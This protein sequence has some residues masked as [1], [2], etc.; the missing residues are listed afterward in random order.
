MAG[1]D[2]DLRGRAVD[3]IAERQSE[4]PGLADQVGHVQCPATV[5]APESRCRQLVEPGSSCGAL[6]AGPHSLG[7]LAEPGPLRGCGLEPAVAGSRHDLFSHIEAVAELPAEYRDRPAPLIGLHRVAA[8]QLRPVAVG[9]LARADHQRTH[10][11]AVRDHVVVPQRPG[12]PEPGVGLLE[13]EVAVVE[14]DRHVRAVHTGVGCAYQGAMAHRDDVEQPL[15]VVEER[16]DPPRLGHSRHDNVRSLREAQ[17]LAQCGAGKPG[18]F[19]GPGAGGIDQHGR[20]D[21]V[22]AACQPVGHVGAPAAAG[23]LGA[24]KA[25]PRHGYRSVL[26]GV[27]QELQHEAGVVVDEEIVRV[28]DCSP[29]AV[30][31]DGGLGGRQRTRRQSPGPARGEPPQRPVG[32]RAESGVRRRV[33]RRGAE[34]GEE[35][36]LL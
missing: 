17:S 26:D 36:D 11:A 12:Q 13:Q 1:H 27:E 30:G 9:V 25:Q 4:L 22:A 3:H 14:G 28:L 21:G 6:E 20:R 8:R 24:V 23:A 33:R 10:A 32:V 29:D 18:K 19:G 7:G 31:V 35:P 34:C 2:H 5:A 16:Q 15:V